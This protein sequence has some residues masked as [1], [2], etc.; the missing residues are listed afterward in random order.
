[1]AS[2]AQ[3]GVQRGAGLGGILPCALPPLGC[4]WDWESPSAQDAVLRH[5]PW[6]CLG[7][8]LQVLEMVGQGATLLFI[9]RQ[10]SLKGCVL[11]KETF[12]VEKV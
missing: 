7:V 10:T 1:M 4:S 6:T 8:Q 5:I 9:L 12:L 11:Q 2:S 3:S